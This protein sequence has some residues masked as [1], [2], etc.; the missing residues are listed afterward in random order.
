MKQIA[1]PTLVTDRLAALGELVR[2]RILRMLEAQELAVGE[3]AKV[4][5][6]PQS[7]VSRHLKVL[8][9]GGWLVKR[10][11]GTTM[12]YKLVLDDLK[13]PSRAL[14][15][16]VRDQIGAPAELAEDARRLQAVLAE[17]MT[18][19]QSFFGRVA[20]EWDQVRGELFGEKF[21][22]VAMLALLDPS[23]TVADLGCGT[24]NACGMLAPYVAKVIAID[25]S[26][27]MLAAARRRLASCNNAEFVAASIDRLPLENSS[28]DAA[29]C[30]LALHHVEKVEPVLAEMHRVVRPGGVALIVDMVAHD[31]SQYRHT[32][33]HRHLGFS[34]SRISELFDSAGFESSRYAELPGE[35]EARGPSLFVATARKRKK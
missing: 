34:R 35:P 27:P 29:V 20:G 17:R 2:L 23:W 19:S 11:H 18:D 1:E 4:V 24:G 14:W 3:V 13:L 10:N 21:S 26:E 6:L 25:Q 8:A 28:V 22:P 32:M 5:Q 31:R 15:M 16:T 12:F 9:D 7:T 30:L 33:G